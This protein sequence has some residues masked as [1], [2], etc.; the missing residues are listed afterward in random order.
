M[1]LD[2]LDPALVGAAGGTAPL[3]TWYDTNTYPVNLEWFEVM[4]TNVHGSGCGPNNVSSTMIGNNVNQVQVSLKRLYGALSGSILCEIRA[5]SNDDLLASIGT[6]DASIITTS[7]VL[8]TFSGG[9]GVGWTMGNGHIISFRGDW[10][11]G[12]NTF[13]ISNS[14]TDL[15]DGF[16]TGK[17]G[18]YSPFNSWSGGAQDDMMGTV[19]G[20]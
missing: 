6:M 19:A 4:T 17:H 2:L 8:Y 1:G 13:S 5:K 15:Y 3:V 14:N 12:V 9:S 16:N 10:T 18:L 11:P 7:G 20:N